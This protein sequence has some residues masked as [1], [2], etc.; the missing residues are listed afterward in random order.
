MT[1]FSAPQKPSPVTD[2]PLLQWANG[3]LQAKTAEGLS[4]GTLRKIYGPRLRHFVA[5][6]EAR[7]V[8]QIEGLDPVLLR[9]YLISLAERH[10]PG[11]CHQYYRVV[12]TFLRWYEQEAAEPGWVN[13]IRRVRPPKVP[14]Q[15]LDTGLR[16]SEL[17]ALDLADLDYVTGDITVRRGKGGK[18][19]T[20]FLG[21]TARRAVRAYLR[22]RGRQSGPLFV[23]RCGRRLEYRGLRSMVAH[24]AALAGVDPPTLHALRRAFAL[25]LL[26]N[27]ADLLSLQKLL[28][29]ANLSLIEK[30]ARQTADDLQAVHARTSPV[31]HL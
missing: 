12:K 28:G 18:T 25:G 10:N 26:R 7:G 20:V 14:K 8:R 5:F 23:N 27:G 3:F 2:I 31:D 15:V 9:E 16:A 11:G 17:L 13:P 1:D 19:R 22:Y 30:V 4:R 6:C 21:Q 29:H 24:R